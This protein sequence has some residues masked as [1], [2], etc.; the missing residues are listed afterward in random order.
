[1]TREEREFTI[2]QSNTTTGFKQT[3]TEE[4]KTVICEE[5]NLTEDKCGKGSHILFSLTKTITGDQ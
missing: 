3:L 2:I 5:R 4:I 1:M